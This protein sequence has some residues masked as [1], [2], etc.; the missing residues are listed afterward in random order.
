MKKLLS[1]LLVAVMVASMIVPMT[2]SAAYNPVTAET[3]YGNLIYN[4]E[5][6]DDSEIE[7][8]KSGMLGYKAFLDDGTFEIQNEKLIWGGA[9]GGTVTAPRF[10]LFN[11]IPANTK[12]F[13]AVMKFKVDTGTLAMVIADNGED[14]YA[15]DA[16]VFQI[17][18]ARP[19]GSA[20]GIVT[21]PTSG[22]SNNAPRVDM[23]KNLVG[24]AWYTL[25]IT[26]D[27]TTS[28][29]VVTLE[30]EDG[31]PYFG[32][33]ASTSFAPT[34]YKVEM[35]EQCFE[36]QTTNNCVP[37]VGILNTG[38]NAEIEF[39]RVYSKSTT[40]TAPAQTYADNQILFSEDFSDYSKFS[41]LKLN[42]GFPRFEDG[43]ILRGGPHS[44]LYA[45]SEG[46]GA[47]ITSLDVLKTSGRYAP[48]LLMYEI[49]D[50]VEE[51]TVSMDVRCLEDVIKTGDTSRN[52]P[53]LIL[54]DN[55][56]G[57]TY[58][59]SQLDSVTKFQLI[60]LRPQGSNT[61]AY[62][63]KPSSVTANNTVSNLSITLTEGT[64]YSIWVHVNPNSTE[65][66]D[67]ST[68]YVENA[69]FII[70]DKTTRT[71]VYED[72]FAYNEINARRVIGAY[73][74]E[75]DWEYDQLNVWAGK[76]DSEFTGANVTLGESIALNYSANVS[77]AVA[78]A[79]AT[80]KFT[81]NGKTTTVPA[82]I[83]DG[84]ATASF[85]N[86][87]PNCI[88]D[89]IKAELYSN[90]LLLDSYSY[91]VKE[92]LNTV[93]TTGTDDE[94]AMAKAALIYGGAAQTY[95]NLPDT[96][97]GENELPAG[98][99]NP[100][101]AFTAPT[102][103]KILAAGLYFD[104]T[105]KIYFRFDT[106]DVTEIKISDG[107]NEVV[108]TGTD[109]AEK[110]YTRELLASELSSVEFTVT[111]YT[112]S[113][114]PADTLTYSVYNYITNKWASTT[115]IAGLVKALYNYAEAAEAFAN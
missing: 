11:D 63:Y 3:E 97:T 18:W 10:T 69:K 58:N 113:A 35:F 25:I 96:I 14:N 74:N 20:T 52:G 19:G 72:E 43:Y 34:G 42:A 32:D 103:D 54:A 87:A 77:S 33:I 80:F 106:K 100:N 60:W 109:I 98:L 51:F 83:T 99:T 76:V 112:D 70:T 1:V 108:Y 78:T 16:G 81:M 71:T 5:F 75:V 22:Y 13:T 64:R 114:T 94:K 45:F 31:T 26:V 44:T 30:K 39:V 37:G 48:R 28:Q 4:Q 9:S 50:S 88:G 110:I 82:T 101:K 62:S 17:F 23:T 24:N 47:L 84:V 111:V 15:G 89:K 59:Y 65:Y 104:Y 56:F 41:S 8:W 79:G 12:E 92:Y 68:S 95:N 55:C 49:P 90:E 21:Y 85:T 29:G 2:V 66:D 57:N 53:G 107:T 86:I 61:G 36:Y 102:G 91:S 40:S 105:N 7:S 93:V 46:E 6:T 27:L 115:N 67:N 38:A 73:V